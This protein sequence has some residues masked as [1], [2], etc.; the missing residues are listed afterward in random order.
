M[1]K[2]NFRVVET[3]KIVRSEGLSYYSCSKNP[4]ALTG[5]IKLVASHSHSMLEGYVWSKSI[6]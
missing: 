2:S 5:I 6:C 3:R 4:N 1:K